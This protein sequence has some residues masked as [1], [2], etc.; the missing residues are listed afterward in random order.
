MS[1]DFTLFFE[2]LM[3]WDLDFLEENEGEKLRAGIE[4]SRCWILFK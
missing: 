3:S 4:R 2:K 1:W